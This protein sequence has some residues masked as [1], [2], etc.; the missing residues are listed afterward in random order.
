MPKNPTASDVL[1]ALPQS[2]PAV[3]DQVQVSTANH[4]KNCIALYKTHVKTAS[5]TEAVRKKEG[6][7]LKLTGE[8]AFSDMFVD[9]LNRVLVVKKGA[10]AADRVVKFVGAY[11]KHITE[12]GT[13]TCSG[14]K[15]ATDTVL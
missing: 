5:V 2:I 15:L 3:F 11:V 4:R 7:A 9:M 6:E 10:A 13:Y 8:R 14:M 1:S 12:K